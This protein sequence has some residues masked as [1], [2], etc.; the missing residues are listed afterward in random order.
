M[1]GFGRS[2]NATIYEFEGVY[3]PSHLNLDPNDENSWKIFAEKVRDIMSKCLDIPKVDQGYSE[4][5]K[6][7]EELAKIK[8]AIKKGDIESK[9]SKDKK[10]FE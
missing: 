2:I 4:K 10:V 8:A 5:V 6:Y 3:D 1:G 9:Y 7:N